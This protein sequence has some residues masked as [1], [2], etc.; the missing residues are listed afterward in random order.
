MRFIR[1]IKVGTDPLRQL[2]SGKPAIMLD[3]VALGMH[4]FGFN[5][6]EPG[7]LRRQQ[8]RQ[9]PHALVRLFDLL[10]VLA[11]P[12]T[13]RLTLVPG[14][15]IPDQEPVGLALLVQA[16]ATPLQ[17]LGG[18]GA[19]GSARAA[20]GRHNRPAP[21]GQGRPCARAAPPS[22]PADPG[23]ARR[24]REATQ[25]GST[26]LHRQ[27]QSPTWAAGWPRRSADLVP[28]F[29]EIQGVGTGNPVLGALPIGFQAAQRAAHTFVGDG[30]GDDA[31]L[32]ADLGR[33]LQGPQPAL[34]AKVAWTAMQEVFEAHQSVL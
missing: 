22:G 12:G 15:I 18:D 2:A 21:W 6:I 27:N 3:Y 16:L 1:T 13:N 29:F 26:R 32:E 28:F 9:N 19:H 14:G 11:D 10:V 33:Q 34:F 25:S 4:P 5:G 8:E 30:G 20:R 31:L 17:E 24:E 7:T 23:F